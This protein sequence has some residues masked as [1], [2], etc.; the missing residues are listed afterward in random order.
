MTL[1]IGGQES[2][3]ELDQTQKITVKTTDT[4]PLKK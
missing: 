4:N 2:E 3:V 1:D